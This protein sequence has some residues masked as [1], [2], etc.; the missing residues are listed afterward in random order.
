MFTAR[1]AAMVALPALLVFGLTGCSLLQAKDASSA[2]TGIAAC[3]LGHAW[4]L[5]T[6][7]LAKQV[8]AALKKNGLPVTTV[9]ADGS[10]TFD[11]KING[12]VSVSSDYTVVVTLTPAA[13]QS[14][15]A[16][17]AH[18]GTATGEA[19]INGGVAIPRNWKN[20]DSAAV[21]TFVINGKDKVAADPEPYVM[22]TTDFDDSAGLEMTC[23]G[24]AMTTHARGSQITQSWKR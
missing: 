16:T 1:R 5:D 21:T 20:T 17:R 6:A 4:K 2:P 10:Q 12:D 9:T 3:A 8:D 19:Y 18:K 24:N 15:V 13:G 11:W 14:T 22:V 23:S 7:D